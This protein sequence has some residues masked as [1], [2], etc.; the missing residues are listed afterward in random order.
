M[1]VP[2][3][4]KPRQIVEIRHVHD[5]GVSLPLRARIAQPPVDVP[6]GMLAPIREDMPDRVR[7]L[8]KDGDLL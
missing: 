2:C 7:I 3:P 5:Q 4:V 8:I 1:E 6:V